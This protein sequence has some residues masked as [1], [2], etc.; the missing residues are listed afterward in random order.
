MNS[1][2]QEKFDFWMS[3]D[4]ESFHQLDMFR[5]FDFANSL[6][7]ANEKVSSEQI[8]ERFKQRYPN[9]L[10]GEAIKLSENGKIRLISYI[11]SWIGK[12][13]NNVNYE[14]EFYNQEI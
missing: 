12:I 7:E 3:R 11:G 4:P 10:D 8:Y 13:I 9:Y 5:M 1:K 6:Y 14:K 2:S